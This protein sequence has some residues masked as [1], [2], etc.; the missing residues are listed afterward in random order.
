MDLEFYLTTYMISSFGHLKIKGTHPC[1]IEQME[2]LG[3]K[4]CSW[5]IW[6]LKKFWL[7]AAGVDI[8]RPGFTIELGEIV[9]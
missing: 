4:K 5:L 9:E 3:Y 6:R 1:F 2:K 8:V 7:R